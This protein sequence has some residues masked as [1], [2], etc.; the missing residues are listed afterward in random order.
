MFA[1]DKARF[2]KWLEHRQAHFDEQDFLP[3]DIADLAITAGYNVIVV[4]QW[5]QHKRFERMIGL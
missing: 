1:D 3:Q 2:Y 4:R 5:E